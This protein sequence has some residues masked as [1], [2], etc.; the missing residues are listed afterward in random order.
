MDV[1]VQVRHCKTA[2]TA[3]SYPEASSAKANHC[4]H[5]AVECL[6]AR[7]T[8]RPASPPMATAH[9][10]LLCVGT[11][12]RTDSTVPSG[13]NQ[14]VRSGAVMSEIP[15][16]VY[17]L[18]NAPGYFALSVRHKIG[19]L[20]SWRG[21]HYILSRSYLTCSFA[22][23]PTLIL[24]VRTPAVPWLYPGCTLTSPR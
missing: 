12:G 2:M 3:S 17:V 20:A 21:I 6:S 10:R 7:N 13:A 24:P 16:Y 19:F 8:S 15:P 14:L 4:L 9:P 11:G 5:S 23:T 18:W 22:D 1:Y